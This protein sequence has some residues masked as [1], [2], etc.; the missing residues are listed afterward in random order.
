MTFISGPLS[1]APPANSPSPPKSTAASPW[2]SSSRYGARAPAR[3][4]TARNTSPP[5]SGAP[6]TA[7]T[8]D[9]PGRAGG[10][11]SARRA[12]RPPGD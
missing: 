1:C 10:G 5:G 7:H 4:P 6:G 8:T 2:G 12:D 11:R 9:A 3:T